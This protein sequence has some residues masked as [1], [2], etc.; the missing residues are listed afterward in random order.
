M[1]FSLGC[2]DATE[3]D[4]W[5]S[6]DL[7][8][9]G[10]SACVCDAATVLVLKAGDGGVTLF[11]GGRCE[12]AMGCCVVSERLLPLCLADAVSLLPFVLLEL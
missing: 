1:S 9:L 11:S 3:D 10:G 8:L 6:A 5:D 12:A 7:L 4:R 2:A